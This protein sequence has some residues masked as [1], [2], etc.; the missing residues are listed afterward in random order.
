MMT[1]IVLMVFSL[2]LLLMDNRKIRALPPIGYILMIFC[3]QKWV[4]YPS[5][6]YAI[7]WLLMVILT[8]GISFM[9]QKNTFDGGV[10]KGVDIISYVMLVCAS[11][12]L[13]SP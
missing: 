13:V 10:M 8:L 11:S 6:T 3:I 7:M 9:D 5:L 4:P 1:L 2:V 12:G